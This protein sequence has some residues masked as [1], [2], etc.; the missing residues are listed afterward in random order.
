MRREK[1]SSSGIYNRTSKI[2]S[3]RGFY[4]GERG[5]VGDSTSE[6]GPLC[7]ESFCSLLRTEGVGDRNQEPCRCSLQ[8]EIVSLM[9][10]SVICK[11]LRACGGALDNRNSTGGRE[12]VNLQWKR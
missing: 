9:P 1:I 2:A 10:H 11:G 7:R 6:F 3:C 5:G 12:G 4:D 8:P